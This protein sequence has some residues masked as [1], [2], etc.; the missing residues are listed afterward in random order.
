VKSLELYVDIEGVK[1][2]GYLR[3]MKVFVRRREKPIA[4][5]EQVVRQR[6]RGNCDMA[7]RF[8]LESLQPLDNVPARW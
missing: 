7:H 8:Y 6:V 2:E 4:N 1:G 5:H 3:E